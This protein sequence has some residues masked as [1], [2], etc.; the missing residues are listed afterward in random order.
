MYCYIQN[1]AF[2][3]IIDGRSYTNVASTTLFSKLNLSIVKH[4]TLYRLQWLN[5]SGK[6]KMNK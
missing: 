1:K 6:M 5:D 2:S 3:L 4:T